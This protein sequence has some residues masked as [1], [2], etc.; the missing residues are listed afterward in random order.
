MRSNIISNP[1]RAAADPKLY[2]IADIVRQSGF[3]YHQIRKIIKLGAL[4]PAY[5]AGDLGMMLFTVEDMNWIVAQ[6]LR[7]ANRQPE[8]HPVPYV[9]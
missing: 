3:H 5:R 4:R 6:L 8:D 9:V 2:S 7:S 1:T